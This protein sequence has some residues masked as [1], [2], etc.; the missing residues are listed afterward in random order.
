MLSY[1]ANGALRN[2]CQLVRWA[3]SVSH[4]KNPGTYILTGQ[5]VVVNELSSTANVGCTVFDA[6]GM[7]QQTAPRSAAQLGPNGYA[8]LP[9]NGIWVAAQANTSIWLECEADYGSTHVETNGEGSF[10]AIQ[11]Q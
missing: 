5:L 10:T 6:Q 4:L 2:L 3:G 11:V 1:S 8:T 7:S 9:V